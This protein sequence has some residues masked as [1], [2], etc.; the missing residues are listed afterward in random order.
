MVTLIFGEGRQEA[1]RG[2][3]AAEMSIER[4]GAPVSWL[5]GCGWLDW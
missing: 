1:H 3:P 5:V 4:R 2:G